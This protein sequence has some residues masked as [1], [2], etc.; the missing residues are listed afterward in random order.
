MLFIK[1]VNKL[2]ELFPCSSCQPGVD[3]NFLLFEMRHHHM[4]K[5]IRKLFQLPKDIAASFP[6]FD[7]P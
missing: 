4:I 7:I 2:R 1:T 6:M 3:R 5:H